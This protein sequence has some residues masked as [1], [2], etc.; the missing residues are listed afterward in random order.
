MSWDFAEGNP[1]SESSGDWY[2]FVSLIGE[3]LDF[4]CPAGPIADVTCRDA[5]ELQDREAAIATDPPYYDNM[6]MPTLRLLYVWLESLHSGPI[7]RPLRD[8]VDPEG[9]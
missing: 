8:Y 7:P 6:D 3:V 4:A 2:R 1:F 5:G 9:S